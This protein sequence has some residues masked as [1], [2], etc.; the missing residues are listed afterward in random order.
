[1]LK[2]FSS[3]YVTE[4]D[5]VYE[6][7]D[8]R[9]SDS[10][11]CMPEFN[12]CE[13]DV[14]IKLQKLNINKSPGCNKLYPRVL[15]ELKDVIAY[16][17]FLIFKK[18]LEM[19]KLPSDWKLAEVTAIFKKGAKTDRGNF[20]PVRLTSVCCKL[21]ESLIRDHAMSYLLDN[22]LLSNR[23]YGFIKGRSTMLQL[24]HNYD[25]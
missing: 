2:Y 11:K 3:V 10:S 8:T 24:L 15:F 4:D 23:Q 7:L 6:D 22:S 17:L 9:V 21:L 13:E 14:R 20:R 1:L 19:G 18:S 12:L 5:E 25:G 16:P